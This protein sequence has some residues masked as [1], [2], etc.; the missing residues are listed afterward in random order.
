[1]KLVV[2]SRPFL[3][4]PEEEPT[5]DSTDNTDVWGAVRVT[6]RVNC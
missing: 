5:T 1:M 2:S 6:S 4:F 3:N